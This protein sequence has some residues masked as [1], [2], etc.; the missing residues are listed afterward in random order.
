MS[1]V[2]RWPQK[3]QQQK[4]EQAAGPTQKKKRV[5]AAQLRVQKGKRSLRQLQLK[6]CTDNGQISV[7]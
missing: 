2:L 5:T 4:D 7:N 1:L 6:P 3:Q